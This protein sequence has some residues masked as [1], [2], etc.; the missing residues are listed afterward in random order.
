MPAQKTIT[1]TFPANHDDSL[2]HRIRNFGE[3]LWREIEEEGLGS[4]GGIETV[5][6]ATDTVQISI[7]HTRK[8]GTVRKLADKMLKAHFPDCRPEVS[9]S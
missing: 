6:R 3:D 1:I 7:H 9:Y 8:I 2:T 4:V 5:D